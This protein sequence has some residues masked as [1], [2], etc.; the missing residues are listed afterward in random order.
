[1]L[2]ETSAHGA[3]RIRAAGAAATL[4]IVAGVTSVSA[5][6]VGGSLPTAGFTY[7]S[8]AENAVNIAGGAVR[9]KIKDEVTV[10]TTYSIVAP[11]E[12]FLGGWHYHNGPV[13]VTVT[14]GT[15]T[16]YGETCDTWDI[17]AGGT[18]IESAGEVLIAKA[19]PSKNSGNVEWFTTRLYPGTADP[20]AV[21]VP[22]VP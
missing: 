14:A 18:Y 4:L 22:C 6:L 5:A 12:A 21:D 3:R 16:F 19:L 20:V 7:I 11:S 9:L 2:P 1:M 8:T 17:S 13:I 15:L 10:K